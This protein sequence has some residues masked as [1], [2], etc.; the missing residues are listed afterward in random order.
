MPK[1]HFLTQ[2]KEKEKEQENKQGLC[3]FVMYGLICVT[4]YCDTKILSR[5]CNESDESNALL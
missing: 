2:E 4:S 1:C 5:W 3:T